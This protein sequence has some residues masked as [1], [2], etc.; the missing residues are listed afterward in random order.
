MPS[1]DL[2]NVLLTTA[3]DTQGW[4]WTTKGASAS[5]GPVRRPVTDPPGRAKP[6]EKRKVGSSILPLTTTL[7]SHNALTAVAMS[8]S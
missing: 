6:P 7:T 8:A 2:A 1:A 4:S 3:V 5:H